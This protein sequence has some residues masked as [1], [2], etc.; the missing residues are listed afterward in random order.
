MFGI[1]SKALSRSSLASGSQALVCASAPSLGAT[2]RRYVSRT[3]AANAEVTPGPPLSQTNS[4][5]TLTGS[6]DYQS[7]AELSLRRFWKSVNLASNTDGT[8]RRLSDPNMTRKCV[9]ETR[10]TRSQDSWRGQ[11]DHPIQQ[12]TLG[13]TY[14]QRMGESERSAET[15]LSARRKSSGLKSIA[16]I[17]HRWLPERLTVCAI[18]I[19]ETA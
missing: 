6:T 9:G 10:S 3:A 14:S 17:R 18:P 1:A 11:I 5:F 2:S 7:E 15:T 8:W 4:T 19:H 12:A 13:A 16:K